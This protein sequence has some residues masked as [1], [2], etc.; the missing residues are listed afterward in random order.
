MKLYFQ[1]SKGEERLLSKV[2][3]YNNT[4]KKINEF[5]DEHNYKSYYCR[6]F[7]EID[8]PLKQVDNTKVRYV[9]DVGSHTEFF[10]LEIETAE[11]L[12]EINKELHI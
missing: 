10:I 8:T 12:K 2:D 9:F 5:L 11:E 4:S 7:Q 3:S 6:V 1:N